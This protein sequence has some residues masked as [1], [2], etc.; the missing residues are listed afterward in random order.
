MIANRGEIVSRVARTAR[1]MGIATVGVYSEPDRNAV[2]ADAVDLAV[3]LGGSA[4][5]ESYL[6]SD[7]VVE[8]AL[9]TGCDAVHPGY[10]FLAENADFA[11][12]VIDAGLTWVG[13]TP[14]QIRLLGDKVAAKRAA[15]EAGVPTTPIG[16]V[17]PDTDPATLTYPLLVKAASGGGGR[18][19][20]VVRDPDELTAAVGASSREALSAFGDGSVFV[21][22]YIEGGRH[23]EVQIL[24]DAYGNVVHLGER[25]C[26]IQ[27]RNQK[28][29]EEAPAPN[30][31]EELRT[32]L[33]EGAL[34]LARH[35]GYRSAGTVEFMVGSS[36]GGEP[37]I[38]F[39]EVNTRLQ[40]EHRVT[41]R[42]TGLDLVELQLRIAGG[43][44]LTFGQADIAVVG[45][46]IEARV[47]AEAPSRG[48]LP[49]TGTVTLY[50]DA[51]GPRDSAI[52]CGS[53]VSADYDSLLVNMVASGADR[54]QAIAELRA[55]LD[56]LRIEGVSTNVAA[57]LAILADPDF[58]AGRMTTAFLDTH[59]EIA[60]AGVVAGDDLVAHL[61]AMV[62]ADEQRNRSHDTVTGFAPSGWRNLRT[63][64]QRRTWLLDGEAHEIE[65]VLAGDNASVAVGRFPT[66]QADGSLSAD[67][68]RRLEVRLLERGADRHVVEFDGVRRAVDVAHGGDEVTTL[69]R[70]GSLRWSRPP[71]FTDHDGDTAGSGP[72]CPLPGTV[73]AV[74]VESGDT[75]ADGELLMV[76][77]AM[78]MEHKITAHATAVVNEVRFRVGDRVDAGDL[79]VVLAPVDGAS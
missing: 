30:L 73:I 79:L 44:S 31:D 70:A 76:V 51:F 57:S 60:S 54:D 59:P 40:V 50:E 43:E 10:G 58:R 33:H 1:R 27:R 78:K 22:P 15:I 69:S 62:F 72:V 16:E 2:H 65:Y 4:P 20:R 36:P 19:M 61:L 25:D 29:V 52:R 66:P 26:S 71:R 18:G 24:G 11:Q 7:A 63:A 17:T 46:A 45:H 68:R 34:A 6:R 47:V 8:A 48:W 39:L 77:E 64:G 75:V 28:I 32:R 74:H 49:S 38:S 12:A 23:I 53:T 21:E 42:V 37:L 5:S 13:P 35:V 41:E 67:T 55:S 14:D 9:D 56:G 3:A